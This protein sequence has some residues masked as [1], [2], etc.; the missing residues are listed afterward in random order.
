[1]KNIT[2]LFIWLLLTGCYGLYQR[3]MIISPPPGPQSVTVP[4]AVVH[5]GGPMPPRVEVYRPDP[6]KGLI[7]NWSKNIFVKVWINSVPPAPPTLEL[8]P[9]Q[10]LVAYAPLETIR[11]YGEGRIKTGPYGWTSVGSFRKEYVLRN[12]SY[13][14]GGFSWRITINDGDFTR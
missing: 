2:L 11:I 6:T 14:F 4:P 10:S 5:Q 1:M 12:Y 3:P 9:E 8:G 7:D 13:N